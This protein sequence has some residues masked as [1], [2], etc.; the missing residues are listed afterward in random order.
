MSRYLNGRRNPLA[1]AKDILDH[2]FPNALFAFVAGSFNRDEATTSSDIDLVVIFEKLEFAWRESFIFEEWPVEAFVHDSETLNYFFQEVDGKDGILSLPSMVIEG[3]VVPTESKLSLKL[4]DMAQKKL[5]EKPS[6][7]TKEAIYHQR[8]GITDLIDDLRD[9]LNEIE[10]K[11][12][13]GALHEALGAFYFQANEAWSASRK[14]ILRQLLKL[15][16]QLGQRWIDVFEKAYKGDRQELITLAEEILKPYGGFLFDG[17]RRNAPK[18]W[19]ISL[20]K[21]KEYE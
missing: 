14:H 4:K 2:R 20:E 10:A 21:V 8:Y 18:E 13:I 11:I 3:E 1:V 19:K 7:W 17:Y 9:P 5:M 12:T 16:P 15:D 6:L